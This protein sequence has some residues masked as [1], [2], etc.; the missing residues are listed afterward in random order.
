MELRRADSEVVEVVLSRRN[1][2]ALLAKLDGHPAGSSCTL[3]RE[4]G[5]GRLL[6]L[7]AEED[8]VHYRDRPPGATAAATE[9]ALRGAQTQGQPFRRPEL[10]GGEFSASRAVQR[11]LLAGDWHGDA[12]WVTDR[13]LP[14]ARRLQA[15]LVV[16]LGDFGV[17]PG[18]EGRRYLDTVEA[19]FAD[20][21]LQL[22]WLDGNHEDFDQLLALPVAP[23]GR[24]PI[25]PGIEHLPRG[26]RWVWGGLRFLALGGAGSIDTL[27]R[28]A[29]VSWWPQE[30]ITDADVAAAVAGGPVE[31]LL[32]HD[33][34][35]D[36][37]LK[38]NFGEEP[39]LRVRQALY[40]S[41]MRLQQVVDAVRPR[42]VVHGHWH[43]HHRTTAR[44]RDGGNYEVVGLNVA[45]ME[46]PT[47]GA[48]ALLDVGRA[49]EELAT[50][51]SIIC[52]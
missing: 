4:M 7:S 13:V 5:D 32:A 43:L 21:R 9:S 51:L 48:M 42:L 30:G 22:W 49:H 40:A 46:G 36:V 12:A 19:A 18:E 17:W 11:V 23:S 10:G 52:A 24:R 50:G 14:T 41:R 44:R 15:D 45:S 3:V 31:V 29:G 25:R 6:V 8:G 27:Y 33:A 37:Q 39:P 16:Q 47:P 20:A 28:R 26:Y 2:R 38:G 1:L 35:L 34:P